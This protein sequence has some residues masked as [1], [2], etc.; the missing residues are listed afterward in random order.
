MDDAAYICSPDFRVEY[1][2][3][4]MINRI[5]F[6]ATGEPCHKVMHGFDEKCPWCVHGKVMKGEHVK[7]E[8]V[9]PKDDR[10]FVV[11]SSPILHTDG[12]ISKL[13]I[14]RDI[15]GYRKLEET[16]R[17]AQKMEAIGTL[18][19]GIAHDFNNILQAISGYTEIS[20]FRELPEGNPARHSMEQVLKAS[21]RAKDLVKQILAFSRQTEEE[22]RPVLIRIIIKEVLK[23]LRASLPSTIEIRQNLQP[24]HE[25]VM[26]DP[27]KIHQVLMNLCTNAAHAMREKGGVLE[28]RSA[29]VDLDSEEIIHY[30]DLTP[31]PYLKIQVS[32]TGHGMEHFIKERI[33]DP[34]FT[35]KETGEGTGLG[36]AVVH[37]VVKNHGGAISVESEVEKG[38]TFTILFP[39]IESPEE[40]ETEKISP[41]PTGNERILFVDDEKILAELAKTMLESFG[42][43]V[44]VRTSSVEALELF[45]AKPDEFD[46]V[47]TDMTMPNMTGDK[48][49]GE[50]LRIRPNIPIILCTGFSEQMTE[51]KAKKVGIRGFVM[52]PIV[53]REIAQIIREILDS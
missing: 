1:L 27:V 45:R 44:V 46:L 13:T 17:Q 22:K 14:F 19:G 9:S 40:T 2:N 11:S 35:T 43:K 41:I 16:L 49:A 37:G 33:F 51:E 12:F 39:A 28:V 32:D 34:Y 52:K 38:T 8:I 50:M 4:A 6:D 29:R 42:Y 20:L 10:T 21:Q 26:T 47:L 23:L 48:L 31:G 30:P 3:P 53:M 7:K 5:G 36:L 24:N 18:A 15:T 25:K